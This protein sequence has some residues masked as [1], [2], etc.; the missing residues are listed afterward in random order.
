MNFGNIA[1]T[2]LT[3]REKERKSRS[4]GTRSLM[5]CLDS[6]SNVLQLGE[7]RRFSWWTTQNRI[8]VSIFVVHQW[9]VRAYVLFITNVKDRDCFFFALTLKISKSQ[10]LNAKITDAHS[11]HKQK[12]EPQHA[13]IGRPMWSVVVTKKT[14]Q[15]MTVYMISLL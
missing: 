3:L 10:I 14:L 2:N 5:T 9:V 7:K 8:S 11:D 12:N 4:R 15:K 1:D 6:K 13:S